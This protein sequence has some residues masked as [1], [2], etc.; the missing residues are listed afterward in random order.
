MPQEKVERLI[1]WSR[2]RRSN[3]RD[4]FVATRLRTDEVRLR[5]VEVEQRFGE[6]RKLE[7]VVL[8]FHG[9]GRASALRAGRAGADSVNVEFVEHA[10][11]A[12]IAAL[13]DVT[14]VADTPPQLLHAMYVAIGRGADVVVVG[15]AHPVPQA[16][17]FRRDFV[18]ELLRRAARGFGGALNLLSVLIG[19]GEE[20]RIE[21]HCS[22]TPGDRVARDGRIRMPNVRAGVDVINRGRDV[23]LFR[24]NR[25]RRSSAVGPRQL[26]AGPRADDRGPTTILSLKSASMLES[27]PA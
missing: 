22:L 21:A 10:V 17:E 4:D 15:N 2:R 18:G 14:V 3:K 26:Q 25:C 11:L 5:G 19:A 20:P 8:F 12:G 13:V 9:F 24:H 1:D 7:E 16:S 6:C 27:P 23:E